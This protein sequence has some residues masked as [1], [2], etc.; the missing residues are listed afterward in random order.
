MRKVRSKGFTLVEVMLVISIIG[1]LAA[2]GIPSILNAYAH[3]MEAAKARNI[4]EV[5]KAKGVLTLPQVVG[6]PGA[7]SLTANDA[8][9]E[10]AVSNLCTALRIDDLSKLTVGGIPIRVGNLTEKADY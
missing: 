8:F 7:M 3:S 1:C 9:D 6:L 5:E 10:E 4:A 2:L